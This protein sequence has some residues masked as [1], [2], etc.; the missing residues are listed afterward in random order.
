M[1]STPLRPGFSLLRGAPTYLQ[2]KPL[3]DRTFAFMTGDNVETSIRKINL[4]HFT[5]T[6]IRRAIERNYTRVSALYGIEPNSSRRAMLVAAC[7]YEDHLE[8]RMLPEGPFLPI[9]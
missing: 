8:E 5:E 2:A 1:P 6:Q 3:N 9:H 7:L 4:D